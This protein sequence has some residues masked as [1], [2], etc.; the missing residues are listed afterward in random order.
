VTFK[1]ESFHHEV[2]PER[3]PSV[4]PFLPVLFFSKVA[5]ASVR[6]YLNELLAASND[7][8]SKR[9][10]TES[11]EL[12]FGLKNYDPARDKRFGGNIKLP[13]VPRPKMTVCVLGD[14]L[15]CDQAKALDIPFRSVDDLKKLNKNKKEVKKLAKS[16]DAFLASDVVIKQIPKLLGPGLN[17]AGKFPTPIFHSDNL[18]EKVAETKATIKFQYKKSPCLGVA[19]GTVEMPE[20]E[21]VTNTMLSINFLVSLLKKNWQNIRSIYIKSSM[22]KPI[23]LY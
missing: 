22:G 19:I 10:F 18:A 8:E 15:H 4:I 1:K 7:P 9:N 21:L 23:R 13:Y 14:T 3:H 12:Q 17:K 2:I 16:F 6:T 11:V 20:D 5:V